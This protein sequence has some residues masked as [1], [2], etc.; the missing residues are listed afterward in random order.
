[1]QEVGEEKEP[2]RARGSL[3]GVYMCGGRGSER[4]IVVT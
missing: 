4:A 3:S 2:N 1:M